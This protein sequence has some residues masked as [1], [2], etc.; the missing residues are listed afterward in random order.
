M[1][2]IKEKLGVLPIKELSK[3]S[4]F[5]KRAPKK[6][7]SEEYV[8]SFVKCVL[9]G[10]ISQASWCREL[11]KVL[12]EP[13]SEQALQAKVQFRHEE[14]SQKLLESAI[15]HTMQN[16]E[17]H[18]CCEF[19]SKFKSVQAHDST[20]VKMPIGLIAS[21]PG[22]SSR[23]GTNAMARIQLSMDLRT[24]SYHK[25]AV[26]S[27]RKNDQS[28]GMEISK[29][30][31]KEELHLFDLGYFQKKLL[32]EINE[33]KAYYLCR[34]FKVSLFKKDKAVN[35]VKQLRSLDKQKVTG[36]SA[37]LTIGKK[38]RIPTRIVAIKLSPEIAQK[39]RAKAISKR[40]QD[41]RKEYDADYIYLLGWNIY[42]TNVPSEKLSAKEIFRIYRLRWR[43]EIIF[44]AWKSKFNFVKMFAKQQYQ[45]PS[46]AII[47]INLILMTIII[48]LTKWYQ[49][50]FHLVVAKTGRYLSLLKFSGMVKYQLDYLHQLYKNDLKKLIEILEKQYCYDSRK[51]RL[52][53]VEILYYKKLT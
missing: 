11:S 12:G 26:T 22:S 42:F 19:L 34:Y 50:L 35:V 2:T 51:D 3:S 18:S 33:K 23:N 10:D 44:K 52:N 17:P 38:E 5:E 24:N 20:C 13:I 25:I 9:N 21:F 41:G 4:N 6:I 46:R 48:F 15:K 14:F 36:W 27:F 29:N 8:Y 45:L 53:F 40:K 47:Q 28:Y 49:L 31:K 7:G 43:I 37:S 39:K 16:N 30:A 1:N 32:K